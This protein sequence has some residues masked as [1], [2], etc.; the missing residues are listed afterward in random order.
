MHQHFYWVPPFLQIL[1]GRPWS[2]PSPERGDQHGSQGCHIAIV[3]STHLGL[4]PSMLKRLAQK[5]PI[6]S[7]FQ[8]LQDNLIVHTNYIQCNWSHDFRIPINR[9]RVCSHRLRVKSN[10]HTPQMER[11]CQLRYLQEIQTEEHFVFRCL[12]P[13]YYEIC[14][15]YRRMSPDSGGYLAHSSIILFK[16]V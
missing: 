1:Y 15:R 2:P 8:Q 14:G 4:P 6:T 13:I 7:N 3:H 16:Y 12:C 9:L 11:I 10:H 5:C